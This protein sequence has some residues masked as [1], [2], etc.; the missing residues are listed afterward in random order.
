MLTKFAEELKQARLNSNVSL[1]QMANKTKIDIKFLEAIDEGNFAFLPDLYIRAFIKEYASL[2]GLNPDSAI[3]KFDAAKKGEF[4]VEEQEKPFLQSVIER[5]QLEQK[6]P[7]LSTRPLKAYSDI[8][9]KETQNSSDQKRNQIIFV[10]VTVGIIAISVLVYFVFFNNNNKI[11]VTERPYEESIE[12]NTRYIEQPAADTSLTEDSDS[13]MIISNGD[14]LLLKI[15]S[16]NQCWVKVISDDKSEIEFMLPPSSS[17]TLKASDNFK[18]I[19]GNSGGIQLSL[20]NK[21]LQF[22]GISG[23]VRYIKISPS[24]VEYLSTRPTLNPQ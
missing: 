2:V 14:S 10:L 1:Q 12:E 7:A 17:K 11:I 8:T 15:S 9:E 18:L 21:L 23:L 24:G 3:K 13:V 19:L 20:N 16:T 5:D 6:K 22:E 4:P